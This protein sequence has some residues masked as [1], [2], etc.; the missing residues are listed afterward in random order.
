MAR[1]TPR[2]YLPLD[3]RFFDDE[4]IAKAGE[5]AAYLY[6]AI[7]CQIKMDQSDGMISLWKIKR[8]NVD[9]WRQRVDKLI[10]VGLLLPLTETLETVP[11]HDLAFGVPSWSRWNLSAHEI[12]D[13]REKGREA[14]RKRWDSDGSPIG[15]PR[16]HLLQRQGKRSKEGERSPQSI[17]SLVDNFMDG[18]EP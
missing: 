1:A 9:K 18:R 5:R 6:L 13:R 10:E 8:L 4:K 2:E 17:G 7:L 16:K 15:S 3:C 12:Q 14:A 11:E